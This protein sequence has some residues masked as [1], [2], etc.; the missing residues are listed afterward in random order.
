M[1][2][3]FSRNIIY[4]YYANNNKVNRIFLKRATDEYSILARVYRVYSIKNLLVTKYII[5]IYLDNLNVHIGIISICNTC[6][7][8]IWETIMKIL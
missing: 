8:R 5:E 3:S 4:L 7:E 6:L 1:V 2:D